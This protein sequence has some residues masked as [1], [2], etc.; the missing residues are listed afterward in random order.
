[1]GGIFNLPC[2]LLP[3]ETMGILFSSVTSITYLCKN[4]LQL[5]LPLSIGQLSNFLLRTKKSK[6]RLKSVGKFSFYVCVDCFRTL[7]V[8]N[9]CPGSSILSLYHSKLDRK[10]EKKMCK[11]ILI[12][13]LI[14][15]LANGSL[16]IVRLSLE[17]HRKHV[18]KWK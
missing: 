3:F 7:S 18:C 5:I 8:S 4:L 2:H 15:Q 17:N 14:V 9:Q 1:M 12:C 10:H 13:F 6:N 16:T 11:Y